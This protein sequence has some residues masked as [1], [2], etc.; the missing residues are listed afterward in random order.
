VQLRHLDLGEFDLLQAGLVDLVEFF[1][2][3]LVVSL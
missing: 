3:G 2:E 1:T